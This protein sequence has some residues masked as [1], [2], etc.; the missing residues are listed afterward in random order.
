MTSLRTAL[1]LLLAL[2]STTAYGAPPAGTWAE[3]SAKSK[4]TYDAA[5][6][7][8]LERGKKA[9]TAAVAGDYAAWKPANEAYREQIATMTVF[10]AA[11][12]RT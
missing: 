9:K 7:E 5:R 11:S 1:G 3:S 6:K 12:K 10:R 8:L 2:A 4:E